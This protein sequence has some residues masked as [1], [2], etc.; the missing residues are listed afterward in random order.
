MTL[1]LYL[2]KEENC[3]MMENALMKRKKML[4]EKSRIRKLKKSFFVCF[5]TKWIK[6]IVFL[7]AN[8]IALE[9]KIF[10]FMSAIDGKLFERRRR[11]GMRRKSRL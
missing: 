7:F 4:E 11:K 8:F 1:V 2:K 3:G 9:K 5:K 6:K 10:L